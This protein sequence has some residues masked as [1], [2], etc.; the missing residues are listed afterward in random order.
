M[1]SNK[2]FHIQ[3]R[4]SSWVS[5]NAT[6]TNL[7]ILSYTKKKQLL[8]SI[9]EN[10]NAKK[11]MSPG[12]SGV[13]MEATIIES[14]TSNAT[15]ST[16]LVAPPKKLCDGESRQTIELA[17]EHHPSHRRR[18]SEPLFCPAYLT[19]IPVYSNVLMHLRYGALYYKFK[20]TSSRASVAFQSQQSELA[21]SHD[22]SGT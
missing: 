8:P 1:L 4:K 22:L 17:M 14:G 16:E 7:T 9:I 12:I 10:R 5:S 18:G 11:A 6:H 21:V 3:L 13:E 20:S 2:L 15:S 19:C